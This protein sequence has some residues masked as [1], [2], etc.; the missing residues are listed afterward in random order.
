[1][2]TIYYQQNS[3]SPADQVALLESFVIAALYHATNGAH[4]TKGGDD[5]MSMTQTSN[6]LTGSIPTELATIVNLED[7]L[8]G[9]TQLNGILPQEFGAWTDMG[10]FQN[11]DF[12]LSLSTVSYIVALSLLEEFHVDNHKLPGSI[13]ESFST[14]ANLGPYSLRMVTWNG[15][16]RVG[17]WY[18]NRRV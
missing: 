13:P 4:W 11:D 3:L 8:V 12:T 6:Q 5:W 14:W 9:G 2:N 10:K 18:W 7:F 17:N 16:P 15:T 1:V